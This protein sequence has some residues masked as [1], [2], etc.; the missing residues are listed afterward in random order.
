MSVSGSAAYESALIAVRLMAIR[1]AAQ[2]THVFEFAPV[3]GGVLPAAAPGAH[4]DLHLPGG[5]AGGR[6]RSYSL[7]L[8]AD[9]A[10]DT[11]QPYYRVGVKRDAHSIGGSRYLH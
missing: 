10:V 1:Y 4:I 5:A 11:A 2:D 7:L 8:S 9:L 3:S 6:V